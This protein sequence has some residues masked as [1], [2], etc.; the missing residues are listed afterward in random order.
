[1]G[2][3]RG[4]SGGHAT[5]GHSRSQSGYPSRRAFGP[6]PTLSTQ[7][8]C[9]TTFLSG[10]FHERE[11]DRPGPAMAFLAQRRSQPFF[12]TVISVG[13]IAVIY[14]NAEQVRLVLSR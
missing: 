3:G 11:A 6:R 10:L 7:V 2:D 1:M 9:D 8:I 4:C 14:D 12:V 13:E 5:G